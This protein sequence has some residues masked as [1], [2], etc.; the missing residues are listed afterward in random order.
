LS[1][2]LIPFKAE[3]STNSTS[4]TTLLPDQ[5]EVEEIVI[6]EELPVSV[7]GCVL[8]DLGIHNFSLPWLASEDDEE[9]TV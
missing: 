7:F 2:K 8:P 5:E 4:L 1:S 9:V 6:Q 3:S